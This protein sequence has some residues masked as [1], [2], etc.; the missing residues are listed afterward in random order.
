[1]IVLT[2]L[3][4][5]TSNNFFQ[6]IHLDSF[7]RE[8]GIRFYNPFLFR[9]HK[10]YPNLNNQRYIYLV[11]LI[12]LL[13][14]ITRILKLVNKSHFDIADQNYEKTILNSKILFCDGWF[15]RSFATTVKYRTYYQ[16]IFNPNID[17]EYLLE[18]YLRKANPEEVIIG[19]H[20]R[21]GDYKYYTNGIYYYNDNTYINKIYQLIT[22]LNIDNY[23]II[24]FSD[25]QT[26]NIEEF[27]KNFKKV[28]ISKGI[29]TVDHFLM[30][31]CDYIIGPPSTFSLWASYIGETPFYH[32]RNADDNISL[33]KFTV[34]NG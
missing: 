2:N 4:G 23:K 28:I 24:L 31:K 15:F 32:I 13:L 1:M 29:E 20:I 22:C 17:K 16:N 9:I 25:D 26:L 33:D 19:V 7:C 34:C 30:S 21:R 14:K 5:Q 10:D 3:Y 11:H 12:I 6:H 8:K 18:T 27:K